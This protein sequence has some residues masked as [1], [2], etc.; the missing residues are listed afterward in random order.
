MVGAASANGA[1]GANG[2]DRG[3]HAGGNRGVSSR[4]YLDLDH[5]SRRG[6]AVIFVAAHGGRDWDVGVLGIG[7]GRLAGGGLINA[8][9][10]GVA[11]GAQGAGG[12]LSSDFADRAVRDSGR[13]AGDGIDLGNLGGDGIRRHGVA[14]GGRTGGGGSYGADG[15]V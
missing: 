5:I 3:D 14:A 12:N 7:R 15:G 11:A 8:G 6:G 2:A 9:L 1:N 13:A 10:V 4:G